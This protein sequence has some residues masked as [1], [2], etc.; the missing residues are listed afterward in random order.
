MNFNLSAILNEH[1]FDIKTKY[2]GESHFQSNDFIDPFNL[3]LLHPLLHPPFC[4]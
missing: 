1:F 2:K 3:Y 4:Q